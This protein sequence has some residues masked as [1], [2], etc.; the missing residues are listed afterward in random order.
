M[1][2]RE[3][4]PYNITLGLQIRHIALWHSHGLYY[5]QKLARWERQRARLFQTVEDLYTMSY[6]LPLL[7][8]MLENAGAIV[9]LPRERDTQFNE[10]VVD[11]DD[12]ESG[13]SEQGGT[14]QRRT[15]EKDNRGFANKKEI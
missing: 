8:P 12:A 4:R 10:V 5:E 15:D 2:T 13:Y 3:N 6:V 7:T 11:N 14:Y 1:Y 9:M